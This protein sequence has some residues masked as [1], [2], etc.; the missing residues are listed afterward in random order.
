MQMRPPTFLPALNLLKY[1]YPDSQTVIQMQFLMKD[2]ISTLITGSL[3]DV[4]R[5]LSDT[6]DQSRSLPR[7]ISQE[8]S[9]PL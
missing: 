6:S 2:Q 8:Q 7:I 3:P 9:I 4:V 1:T 5:L